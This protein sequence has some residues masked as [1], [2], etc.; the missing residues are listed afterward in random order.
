MHFDLMDLCWVWVGSSPKDSCRR[1]RFFAG[2]L[3]RL[4]GAVT[5][6]SLDAAVGDVLG[7]LVGELTGTSLDLWSIRKH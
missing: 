5:G 3:A 4:V 7:V 1:C 2:P 6:T